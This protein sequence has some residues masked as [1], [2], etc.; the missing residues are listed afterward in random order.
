MTG[1]TSGWSD[2]NSSEDARKSNSPLLFETGESSRSRRIGLFTVLAL[3]VS[4]TFTFLMLI[5][6]TPITPTIN[7][8]LIAA[9][10]NGLLILVLM[11]LIGKEVAKIVR[12]R[13][14]GRSAARLHVRIIALFCLVASFPAILVAVVAGIT[15]DQGL[16]RWFEIGTRKIIESSVSVARAYQNETTRVLMGN[17]LSMAAN[18]NR[19]RQLY[20]LDRER[21][22]PRCLR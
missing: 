15:F 5:G 17:T 9:V 19:N 16:D 21:F 18:L 20:V 11:V 22:T 12:S 2:Q 14:K 10:V 1:A 4:G 8:V 6:L 3:M 7:E 13:R